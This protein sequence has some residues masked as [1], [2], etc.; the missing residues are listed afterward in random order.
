M[1]TIE[2]TAEH[3]FGGILE[4]HKHVR[5]CFLLIERLADLDEDDAGVDF[6]A[7]RNVTLPGIVVGGVCIIVGTFDLRLIALF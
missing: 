5:Q 6:R 1:I 3:T 7:V 4:S 2:V